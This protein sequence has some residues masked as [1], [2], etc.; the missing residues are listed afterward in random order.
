MTEYIL[1]P[2][3]Y[4]MDDAKF[5]IQNKRGGILHEPGV[6][7][8]FSVYILLTY[9]AEKFEGQSIVVI[10]PILFNE[11]TRK[12]GE[13]FKSDRK[14]VC[15]RGTP[16]ERKEILK[17]LKSA[18]IVLVSY[19]I[20]AKEIQDLKA[21]MNNLMALVADEYKFIKSPKSKAFK[22]F[23][24]VAYKVPYLALMNGTPVVKSP[25]DLFPLVQLINPNIYVTEK[26]FLRHHAKYAKDATGFPVIIGWK[27]L[28][29]LNE[30]VAKTCR[31][32]LK[33]DVLEL[34]EKQL[35]IKQFSLGEKH[36]K[37]LKEF[38]DLGFLELGIGEDEFIFAQASAL[39]HKVRQAT[40]SPEIVGV[41]EKSAYFDMLD[42]TL[43]EIGDEQGILFAHYHTTSNLIRDYFDSRGIT[44]GIVDGRVSPKDKDKA[45]A[46]F[47]EGK[48]K[49][50]IGNAKSMGVGLDLQHCFNVVFFEL[51]YEVD[52]FW[53]GMDRVHRPGQT[54]EP[55]IY[56]L[57]AEKTP[58]VALLKSI[59]ENVNYVSEILKG[60]QT[61]T[62][63]FEASIT[64]KDQLSWKL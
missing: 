57:V 26:N 42:I 29:K 59:M 24:K 45:I 53:Q 11:W 22:A 13:Y 52:N 34:P 23:Q 33:K 30:I 43:E 37:K 27:N 31:R 1:E 55:N 19:A 7:K 61:H 54:R 41:D 46:D 2:F 64:I 60:N 32:K 35:I 63:F 14:V 4:Q 16:N 5:F 15:Y 49:W 20:M 48:V 3:E 47:K 38:W 62:S 44:Y 10:P 9:L 56:V 25:L 21:N 6:G 8:T 51:D 18:D 12:F 58:A 36:Y 39:L 17:T 50:L 40:V 28:D